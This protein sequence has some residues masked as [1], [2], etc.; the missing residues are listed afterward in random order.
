MLLSYLIMASLTETAFLAR[1]IIKWSIVG[2]VS[3][4]FLRLAFFAAIDFYRITFPPPALVPNNALGKLPKIEF[5][6]SATSSGQ[7]NFT[8]QT[9][10]GSIPEASDAARVYFMPK[11]RSNL[12]SLSRAQTLVSNI[13]FTT[14]PRQVENSDVYHWIDLKNPLRSV[15]LDIVTGQFELKYAYIHELTLFNQTNVPSPVQA[16][17]EVLAFFQKLGITPTDLDFDNPQVTYLHLVG[18]TLEPTTSQSQ[19]NAVRVDIFRQPYSTYPILT[20]KPGEANVNFII[21]GSIAP[22]KDVLKVTYN[23]WEIDSKTMGIYALKTAQTAYAELQAGQGYIASL[24]PDN[25]LVI[26]DVFL[27]YYDSKAPQLFLQPVYVFK[28]ENNFMAYVPAVAP[29]W[30]E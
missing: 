9:V 26:T 18:N 30:T 2:L 19:A 22:N 17:N 13:G 27:A 7:L 16:T 21:G 24:P 8:V 15:D 28:G 14:T 10:S 12:L 5:P 20:D 6:P 25:N 3:F 29:P 4:I 1:K 11:N 23:H